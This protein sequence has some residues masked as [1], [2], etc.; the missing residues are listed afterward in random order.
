MSKTVNWYGDKFVRFRI[1]DGKLEIDLRV[2]IVTKD[3]VIGFLSNL[4][5][6]SRFQYLY[7]VARNTIIEE[8]VDWKPEGISLRYN[9]LT[10]AL[11]YGE[12]ADEDEIIIPEEYPHL[13]EMMIGLD[14]IITSD[15]MYNPTDSV[16]LGLA[17]DEILFKYI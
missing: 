7:S 8:M 17:L 11:N 12:V 6:S 14:D 9:N 16:L 13:K 3:V 10:L 4:D 1:A 2:K 5:E 15:V